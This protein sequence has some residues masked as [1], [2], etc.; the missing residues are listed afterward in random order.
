MDIDY[1]CKQTDFLNTIPYNE[2]LTSPITDN[3]SPQA[4]PDMEKLRRILAP[5]GQFSPKEGGKEG[6]EL[7]VLTFSFQTH[8]AD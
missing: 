6:A 2:T 3:T 7:Y 1:I 8:Q 4:C 5:C